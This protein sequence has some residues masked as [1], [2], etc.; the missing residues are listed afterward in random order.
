MWPL[1]VAAMP[2]RAVPIMGQHCLNSHWQRRDNSGVKTQFN[3]LA[4]AILNGL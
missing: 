3:E 1:E 2:P 4:L